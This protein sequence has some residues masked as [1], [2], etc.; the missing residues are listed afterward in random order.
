MYRR[1]IDSGDITIRWNG[2][3]FMWEKD[4]V[5]EETSPDGERIRWEKN[6]QFDV[7]GYAVIGKVW[8]RIPGAAEASR[9]ASVQEGASDSRWTR[10]GIQAGHYIRRSQLF[11]VSKTRG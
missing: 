10:A 2:E 9:N 8:I 4:P 1:D 11:P 5:F 7:D 3:P 6:V